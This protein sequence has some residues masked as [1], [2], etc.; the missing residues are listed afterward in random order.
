MED[1]DWVHVDQDRENSALLF[2][3]LSILAFHI[4]RDFLDY[5]KN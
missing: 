1:M 4:L 3:R 2:T 5:L